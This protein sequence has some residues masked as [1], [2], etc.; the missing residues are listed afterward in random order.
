MKKLSDVFNEKLKNEWYRLDNAGKIYPAIISRRTTTLFRVSATL[1]SA[2]K[3]STLQKAL[4]NMINRCPYY[5]VQL[6]AGVFWNYFETNNNIPRVERDSKYPCMN[7]P[8]KKPG[9][10]PFRIRAYKKRI[11]AEFSHA[12]TDG[13]GAVIF[14]KSLL[15]EYL[16]IQGTAVTD[17]T[18]LLFPG[19]PPDPLE[20]QDGFKE[21]FN[22]DIPVPEKEKK[23][24]HLPFRKSGHG[25]YL[26][27]TGI[28]GMDKIRKKAAEYNA[29]V[30]EFI[31]ALYFDT[32][33][34]IVNSSADKGKKKFKRPVR[35]MVPVNLRK[36]YP[37]CSKTMRNFFLTVGPS[38]DPRLGTYSLAEIIRK[39]HHFMSVEVD[40]KYI[41]RQI[42]RNIKGELHP[43]TRLFPLFIKNLILQLV[44]KTIGQNPI[45]SSLSNL[46]LITVP[47]ELDKSIERF[48]FIPAPNRKTTIHCSIVSFKNKVYITF[49]RSTN[50]SVVE[51]IFFRK[52][53]KAGIPVKIETN[54]E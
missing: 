27:T 10:F 41:N 5:K 4:E 39:I 49:G 15:A 36:I 44:Y 31:L 25:I 3:L 9:M 21:N 20:F 18:D 50:E 54:M 14:L 51:R 37:R 26:I 33:L 23:A 38:I 30:T 17:K 12:L 13:T 8:I 19:D 42:A 45:T 40:K 32:F 52:L 2:V 11:A 29:S 34:D 7:M 43:V 1:N 46:G 48:E 47:K 22:P 53:I 28:A 35:I 24:F 6:R 16:K